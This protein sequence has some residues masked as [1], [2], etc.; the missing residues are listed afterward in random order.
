M[1]TLMAAALVLILSV[2]AHAFQEPEDFRGLKWGI[3]MEQAEAAIK[4]QWTRRREAGEVF[5]TPSIM[6]F[7]Y[8]ERLKMLL[9]R[10][11]IGNIPVGLQLYFLD[12]HFV[13]ATIDFKSAEFGTIEAAFKERY[14]EPTKEQA[15][16]IQNRAGARFEQKELNWS[17]S[18]V[19]ILLQR[20]SGKITDGVARISRQ[21]Y[22]KYMVEKARE[23]RGK[24]AK[25]L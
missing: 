14:G 11:K 3:S 10:D 18:D 9:Y 24:A 21:D 22:I 8:D 16:A 1:K 6:P 12:D 17:G 5:T 20:Y 7:S 19:T 13:N 23:K 25:D 4:E 15:T 2:C